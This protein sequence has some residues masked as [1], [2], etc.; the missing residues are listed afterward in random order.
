M[1]LENAPDDVKLAVD[2]IM[3]LESHDIA[4]DVVLSALEMV[5]RDFA[6]KLATTTDNRAE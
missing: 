1:S 5:K 2:L 3:L 6:K 4:P